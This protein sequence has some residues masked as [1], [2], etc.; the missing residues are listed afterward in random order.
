MPFWNTTAFGEK[1]KVRI[2]QIQSYCKYD[3]PDDND[4]DDAKSESTLPYLF[5]KYPNCMLNLANSGEGKKTNP[6]LAFSALPIT[7]DN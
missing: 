2:S 1:Y 4:D 7:L 6:V 5:E 3:H